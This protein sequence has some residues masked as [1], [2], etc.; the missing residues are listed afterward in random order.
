MNIGG[1]AST[2]Q[3][4]KGPQYEPVDSIVTTAKIDMKF[5]K[6]CLFYLI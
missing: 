4:F 1:I 3:I 2:I 5:T 6:A